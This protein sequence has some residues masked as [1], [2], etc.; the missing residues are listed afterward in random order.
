MADKRELLLVI[1]GKDQGAKRALDGVGDAA[2]DSKDDLSK[3]SAGLKA[4]DEQMAVSKK[5]AAG[6]RAEI[7]K[8][9]D[10]GLLK[11]LQKAERE[12]K[13]FERQRKLLL[14]ADD[15]RESAEEFSLGFSQRLGPLLA[16]GPVNPALVGAV[17]AA[18]PA[19][20]AVVSGA[21]T[22]GV[23]LAS[24]GAGLKLA[25]TDPAVQAAGEALKKE[26]GDDLKD[27]AKPFAPEVI[28]ATDEIR[29]AWRKDLK[30][31]IE[32]LFKD[33]AQYVRPLTEAGIGFTRELTPGLR[34]ANREA[35][36]LVEVL[37]EHGPRAG[38][39]MSDALKR[40]SSDSENTAAAMDGL[41]TGI[42]AGAGSAVL[43][44]QG[45]NKAGPFIGLGP[46]M[47]LGEVGDPKD[48]GKWVEPTGALGD[49]LN[50]LA[51]GAN[52]AGAAMRDF[53]GVMGAATDVNLNARQSMRDFEAA[54]DDANAGIKENGVSLDINTAKGRENQAALDAIRREAYDAAEGIRTMGGSQE[55]ANGVLIRG[56]QAF[57]NAAIAAGMERRAAE[58]LAN[59][60][61]QLP[62]VNKT[63]NYN[64]KPAKEA[65]SRV[66][67]A[68]GRIKD[69]HR[70]IYFTPYGLKVPGGT[71]TKSEG[72]Y[73][74]GPGTSTSDS[75]SARL[76]DGEYVV[77]AAAVD[78]IGIKAL[79][80]INSGREAISGRGVS[81][82]MAAGATGGGG[83]TTTVRV[84]VSAAPGADSGM[85]AKIVEA[86]R[87]D[88]R[89]SGQD[90]ES[91]WAGAS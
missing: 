66:V 70:G 3:M 48:V 40:L 18:A 8:S 62:N 36:P 16:K 82:W 53:Y 76:S 39:L 49:E 84:L 64:D 45:L 91:Y 20:S 87:F 25:F 2:E 43:A 74:S 27:A 13:G 61:F 69:I 73:V 52:A 4:L 80:A 85:L 89:G 9:G 58:E 51:G 77:R 42:E 72:G 7:G 31:E 63:I 67:E 88:V 1:R 22:T 56:K 32:G 35:A 6:L 78:R 5:T 71:I 86:L 50:D 33:S 28:R 75:I 60:L 83:G 21:I 30:P 90:V 15:G 65:I 12:L 81:K 34:D 11:D 37:G 46:L 14:G 79:D 10:L 47:W 24:V 26:I 38:R 54:I 57:T 44:L 17:V 55:E 41:F 29:A 68:G 59:S 19:V 23:A